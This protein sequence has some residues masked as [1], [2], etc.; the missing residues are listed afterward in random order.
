MLQR[1]THWSPDY[2]AVARKRVALIKEYRK[3]NVYAAAVN[4]YAKNPVCFIEGWVD[5]YDP[6]NAMSGGVVRMPFI[7]FDRQRE[8]IQF[9]HE[10]L[11]SETNGLVEK[12]RDVGATWC[13]V[14][15][16]VWL[17]LF[18]PGS[19]VGWGSRKQDLVDRIGDLDSIFEK[20]RKLIEGLPPFFRPRYDAAFMKIVN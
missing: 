7:L 3:R 14:A 4:S 9:L 15:F 20:M 6:R 12:T 19:S 16:S 13:G 5:T 2:T 8:L 1:P 17:W 10:C 18:Y 11:T